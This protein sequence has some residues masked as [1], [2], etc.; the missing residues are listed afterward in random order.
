MTRRGE[1]EKAYGGYQK[2]SVVKYWVSDRISLSFDSIR[3][4]LAHRNQTVSMCAFHIR[5]EMNWGGGKA[6]PPGVESHGAL[7]QDRDRPFLLAV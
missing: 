7:T 1:R 2:C 6:R 4:F 5:K 3:K